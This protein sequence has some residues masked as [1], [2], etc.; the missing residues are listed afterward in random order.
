MAA[1]AKVLHAENRKIAR[2]IHTKLRWGTWTMKE[3]L[4]LVAIAMLSG[5]L[6]GGCAVRHGQNPGVRECPQGAV[7]RQGRFAAPEADLPLQKVD[8]QELIN[9]TPDGGVVEAPLG[10]YVLS[11]SLTIAGRNNLHVAFVPGTQVRVDDTA[12]PV[13]AIENCKN[14]KV[15][16]V[17]ARHV[18][19]LPEYR[20]HG[21]VVLITGS[22]DI[23]IENCELNGCGAVG[24]KAVQS[25]AHIANCHIHHNTFNAIYLHSCVGVSVIGNIIEDNGNTLQAEGSSGDIQWSDNLVRDNGGYWQET[26]KPGLRSDTE[27]DLM[28]VTAK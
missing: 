18:K 10:R 22:A 28:P 3:R 26:R 5:L 4:L 23:R 20:C 14:V 11:T 9:N 16:G 21:E 7:I 19:P 24:V 6:A 15:S 27:A 2:A 1:T 17:R 13:I 25:S 12:A 8:L